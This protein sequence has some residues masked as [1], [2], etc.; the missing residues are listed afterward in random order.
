MKKYGQRVLSFLKEDW[1]ACVVI[2]LG[3]LVQAFLASRSLPFLLGH[4][5]PDAAFYYFQIARH[6]VE[7]TGSTFDGLN[8]TNGYHPLWLIILLPIFSLF[9]IGGTADVSPLYAALGVSVCVNALT[10]ICI[11][12]IISR[13]TSSGRV[14]AFGLLLWS[15]NPFVL[16]E[17]LNGLETSLALFLLSLFILVA[18]RAS[19]RGTGYLLTGFMGGLMVLARL[20]MVFYLGALFAWVLVHHGFREGL[21]RSIPAGIV[22]ICVVAPWF[23]WNYWMF[24]MIGTSASNANPMVN[25]ALIIQD[26]G[27][28]IL[29]SIKAVFYSLVFYGKDVLTRTGAAWLLFILLGAAIALFVVGKVRVL[30]SRK[31]I[32]LVAFL[33][34]GFLVLFFAN[35]GVRFTGRSWYFISFDLFLVFGATW[36]LGKLAL[37]LY[38][39]R[40]LLSFAS[41]LVLST[42]FLGWYG[43]L[44]G[45][46]LNQIGAY[47]MAQWM[48]EQVPAGTPVGVFNAGVQGYFSHVRVINLDGL[49]NNS[50]YEAMRERRLWTYIEDEHI[51]YISDFDLYLSYRYKSFLDIDDPF[52]HLQEIRRVSVAGGAHGAD[53][54]A[55]YKVLGANERP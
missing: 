33:F 6:V 7:G 41:V 10:A 9:S 13:F 53:S 40:V 31:D 42:F 22:A 24:H 11:L 17:T 28:S 45:Q 44:R 46:N 3:V 5:L 4:L 14:R 55:L 19:E 38:R 30:A 26:H 2:A 50:A 1:L 23:I 15:L 18:L 21:R 8:Q 25:H 54:M 36:M 52:T 51:E 12:R 39:E 37:P 48:N 16:F 43:E 49:V 34:L 29:Q 27:T 32:P 35:A 20:D 47:E